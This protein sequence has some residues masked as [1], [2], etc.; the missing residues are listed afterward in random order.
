MA[1]IVIAARVASADLD[2]DT[3]IEQFSLQP[4]LVWRRGEPRRKSGTHATSGFNLSLGDAETAAEAVT[5]AR[6]FVASAADLIS[7][8][9]AQDATVEIDFGMMVGVEGSFAPSIRLDRSVLTL[10]AAAGVDVLISAYP[11]ES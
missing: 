5:I 10:F 11:T 4:S 6:E 3:I 9:A 2:V 7:A 8:L 1:H